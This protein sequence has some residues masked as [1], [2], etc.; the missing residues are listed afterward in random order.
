M[1][2]GLPAASLGVPEGTDWLSWEPLV[3]AGDGNVS[4]EVLGFWL[5]RCSL[6]QLGCSMSA[7]SLRYLF[8]SETQQGAHRC[9]LL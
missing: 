6:T 5:H 4:V 3:A 2:K 9:S 1:L 7:A 8:G